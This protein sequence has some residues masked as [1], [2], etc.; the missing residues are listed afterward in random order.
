MHSVMH[1]GRR[2][3]ADCAAAAG[4]APATGCIVRLLQ[5]P[6]QQAQS[7]SPTAAPSCT[8][9]LAPEALRVARRPAEQAAQ[10]G[11][12]LVALA[13]RRGVAL[14]A[15]GLEDLGACNQTVEG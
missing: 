10:V 4:M 12:L 7:R 6:Q 3:A 2:H 13:R 11:T 14:S 8:E 9:G 1:G 15:L 5:R